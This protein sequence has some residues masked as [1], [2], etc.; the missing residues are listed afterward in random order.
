MKLTAS[1]EEGAFMS[2]QDSCSVIS[3]V[4]AT[5]AL[6]YEIYRDNR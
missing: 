3:I 1:M 5:L 4:I 2:F 6:L